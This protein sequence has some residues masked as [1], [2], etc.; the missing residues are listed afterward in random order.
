MTTVTEMTAKRI[1]LRRWTLGLQIITVLTM[2]Y[3]VLLIGYIFLGPKFELL[4][5]SER[6]PEHLTAENFTK[7]Q[8]IV[9]SLLL[10]GTELCWLWMLTRVLRMASHFAQ[11][12][13]LTTAITRQ[14]RLFG[15]GLFVLMA[16][17]LSTVPLIGGYLH[18]IGLVQSI[19]P[20]LTAPI[21]DGAMESAIGGTLV[22][23]LSKIL[24]IGI[25]FREEV[26][27]T[28]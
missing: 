22:F 26:D 5:P 10:S 18:S 3:L 2:M 16:L 19:G 1:S 14:L 21:H 7:G 17:E 8:R 11:G 15:I 23:I 9:A 27:L 25:Q 24:D 28:V 20:F 12:D 4:I 13:I 6:G